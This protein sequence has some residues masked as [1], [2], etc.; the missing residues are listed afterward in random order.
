MSTDPANP[1]DDQEQLLIPLAAEDVAVLGSDGDHLATLFAAAL[2]G[3]I[4]NVVALRHP[5]PPAAADAAA[6]RGSG[7]LLLDQASTHAT[8]VICRRAVT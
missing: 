4:R 2:H 1:N 3:L 6:P 8:I 5:D 7:A